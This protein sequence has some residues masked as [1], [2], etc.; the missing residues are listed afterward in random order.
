M[1]DTPNG[2]QTYRGLWAKRNPGL[3]SLVGNPKTADPSAGVATDKLQEAQSFIEQYNKDPQGT[4]KTYSPADVTRIVKFASHTYKTGTNEPLLEPVSFEKSFK[5]T[6]GVPYYLYDTAASKGL[7]SALQPSLNE[8]NPSK[9][10]TALQDL[11]GQST[12]DTLYGKA[13]TKK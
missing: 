4:L 8:K 13:K 1:S 10:K 7:D 11:L 2:E 9:Y 6:T 3:A 12:A 5:S